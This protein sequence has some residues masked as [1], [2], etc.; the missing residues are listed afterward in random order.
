MEDSEIYGPARHGKS[1]HEKSWHGKIMARSGLE[2]YHKSDF[3]GKTIF[4]FLRNICWSKNS[5]IFLKCKSPHPA[6]FIII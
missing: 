4:E 2:K 1:W 3:G 6:I 5:A